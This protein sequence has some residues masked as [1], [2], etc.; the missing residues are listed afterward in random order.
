MTPPTCQAGEVNSVGT[1]PTVRHDE[2]SAAC[3][4]AITATRRYDYLTVRET[5]QMLEKRK[6]RLYEMAAEG[7][8]DEVG[9]LVLRTKK[10]RI[11]IGIPRYG[12]NQ[13]VLTERREGP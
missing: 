13:L 4:D 6:T 7:L 8:L 10:G 5:A 9:F 1:S 12:S 2:M 11:W 3:N